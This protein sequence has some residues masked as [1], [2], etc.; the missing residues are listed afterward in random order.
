[1]AGCPFVSLGDF[2]LLKVALEGQSKVQCVQ[3]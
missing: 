3:E 2:E 1:M